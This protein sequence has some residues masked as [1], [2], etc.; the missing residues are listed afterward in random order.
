M[1]VEKFKGVK[2]AASPKN[3]SLI[4][5][6]LSAYE[7]HLSGNRE[8]MLNFQVLNIEHI[9]PQKPESWNLRRSEIKDY[10]NNIG[11][12]LLIDQ[13]L[14]SRMG[15][16]SLEDK[17][18]ILSDSQLKMNKKILKLFEDNNNTWNQTEIEKRNTLLAEIS[19]DEIWS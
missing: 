15:N 7:S 2:Y 17:I 14:N 16:K 6:I 1:F 11:N 8:L 10:V 12:L 3:R 18:P 4:K 5:Y 9:L 19:F 13:I